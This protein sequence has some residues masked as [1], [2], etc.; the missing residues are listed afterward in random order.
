MLAKA[1]ID[2]PEDWDVYVDRTLLAYQTSVQC[3]T[4]ATPSRVLF[5]R[6]LRLPV[7]EMYGVSTDA[8]VRSVVEYVQHLRRD[9]ERV[10]E[11]VR[12]KAGR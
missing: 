12:M 6:E 11:V 7:H 1:S 3:T 9:L 8:N 2:H 5:G 10:Y 4:G